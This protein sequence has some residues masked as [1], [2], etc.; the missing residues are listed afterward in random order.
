MYSNWLWVVFVVE[1]LAIGILT[2]LIWQVRSFLKQLFPQE[3]GDFRKKLEELIREVSTVKKFRQENLQN[4]QKVG[5][6]RF[7]PYQDTGGDQ[8]F[9]LALLD[10][11][12]DGLVITSL[13]ART[14]TRVFAKAVKT[15]RGVGVRLSEE[16]QRL[17]T[18][19]LK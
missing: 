6:K 11:N 2:Y 13:H 4:I 8:S 16:E 1:V 19:T 18:E 17:L 14:G 7:N 10:G 9:T 15:G 3:S 5:L 12:N